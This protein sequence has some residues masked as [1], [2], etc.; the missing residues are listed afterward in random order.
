L[1]RQQFQILYQ[2]FVSREV[3]DYL[4]A[5][6]LEKPCGHNE[7]IE[8]FKLGAD[9]YEDSG[10]PRYPVRIAA[11]FLRAIAGVLLIAL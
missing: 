3:E 5:W 10:S 2:C 11:G 9:S 8:W 1:I 4:T 6:R 7:H